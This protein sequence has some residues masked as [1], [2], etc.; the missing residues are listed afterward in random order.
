M[1]D[2]PRIKPRLAMTMGD[3]AGVGPEICLRIL[4]DRDITGT[5][6]LA[7]F[8]DASILRTLAQRLAI[9]LS[10]P[11]TTLENWQAQPDSAPT[12][13]IDAPALNGA[14]VVPGRVQ[15]HCGLASRH[16]VELAVRQTIADRIDAVVTGPINKDAWHQAGFDEPGHTEL[17]TRLT[18][19]G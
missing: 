1:T 12:V 17:L 19:A 10:T 2:N 9:P 14:T 4:N 6:S 16:Y 7:I 3:P 18:G 15:T 11:V 5:C 13:I 8:G